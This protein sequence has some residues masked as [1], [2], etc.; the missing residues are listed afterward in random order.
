LDV[1]R[2]PIEK[3]KDVESSFNAEHHA[4]NEAE[5]ANEDAVHLLGESLSDLWEAVFKVLHEEVNKSED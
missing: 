2:V 5:E 1:S 4:P 3:F